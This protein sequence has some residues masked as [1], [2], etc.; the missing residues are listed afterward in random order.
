[1]S[2]PSEIQAFVDQTNQ[3]L[4]EIDREATEGVN[5]VRPL[6]SIFPNNVRLIQFFAVLNNALL[7]TDI[8]RRRIQAIVDRISTPD[9]TLAE[10]HEAGEDLGTLL[11]SAIETKISNRNILQILQE[12]Q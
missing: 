12:L 4:D 5:L 1:M 9:A 11:G 3:E 2:I 10:I 8:C 6:L 7:F